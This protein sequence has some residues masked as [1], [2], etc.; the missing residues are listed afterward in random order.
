MDDKDEAKVDEKA[1]NR[2]PITGEP[3]SH[4]L[5]TGVG[6]VGGVAAGAAVGAA[7]GG[8]VGAVVGGAVGAVAGGAAGHAMGEAV[9]PTVEA[10]YWKEN[11][12]KR[13]YYRAGKEYSEYEPA[14]RYGWE[15]AA[16]PEYR[17]REWSAIEGDLGRGWD[18][19]KGGS[20]ASWNDA[21]EAAHDAWSRVTRPGART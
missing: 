8:P 11:Y 21:R 5:G 4:P 16:K 10:G 9:D 15:S 13:P 17:D 19:V 6:A 14:Y 7:I 12:S 1:A 2:D 3:G 18:K 20:R